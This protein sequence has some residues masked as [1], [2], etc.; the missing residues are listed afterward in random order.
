MNAHTTT[1]VPTAAVVSTAG[2]K[3]QR[4][5]TLMSLIAI[6]AMVILMFYGGDYYRLSQA[7]RA[8]SPKHHLLRPSG[9]VG[10]NLGLLGV[11]LLCGIFLYPLRKRWGWLRKQGS[12][13]RWLDHHVVLGVAAPVCIALHASFK[14]HGLA[15]IAFWVMVAVSLSGLVGRY[16]YAQI[17]RQV[18]AAES[19]LL[20]FQNVLDRQAIVPQ[21]D[22][23]RLLNSPAA[24][25]VSHWSALTALVYIMASDLAR[26]FR[27][28]RLRV[29]ILGI[30]STI[31]S[32]CGFLPSKNAQFEE[33]ICLACKQALIYRRA[34]FLSHARR[35]FEL[36]HV[37][38]KPFSYAF[39]VLALIHI[40]VA[41]LLGF[42]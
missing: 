17:P 2:K 12:S 23:R 28:A 15:G 37:V 30:K 4:L 6:G 26:P 27:I 18:A 7:D 25:Q 29:S 3:H 24:S 16:L 42:I 36:W 39:A 35:V 41:M 11:L 32:L 19:S 22:L 20:G 13:K 14:F 8:F 40:G 5:V 1:L 38:H 10:I 34:L 21:A 9:I 33:V 31:R